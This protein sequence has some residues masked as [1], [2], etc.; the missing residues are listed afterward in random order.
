MRLPLFLTGLYLARA[1]SAVI[2]KRGDWPRFAYRNASA[3]GALRRRGAIVITVMIWAGCGA[4][5][6]AA[7][8]PVLGTPDSLA[9]ALEVEVG[10]D[11]VQLTLHVTNPTRN[12]IPLEFGSAQR[13]D[14][15][16]LSAAGAEVWRWSADRAFAQVVS[17]DTAAADASR[18][19]QAVWRPGQQTGRFT[20]L[21]RL[22][23]L[24]A[25]REQETEFELGR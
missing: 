2:R 15:M 17:T 25:A 10:A 7:Q 11:S 9:M 23:T 21:G 3:G 6:P 24:P 16:V 14:F 18:R 5:P 8:A 13:F 4:P 12:P 22:L 1:A 19:Y 20:V